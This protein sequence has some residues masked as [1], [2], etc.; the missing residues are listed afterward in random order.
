[1]KMATKVAEKNEEKVAELSHEEKKMLSVM[2]EVAKSM[3]LSEAQ[4]LKAL[5]NPRSAYSIAVAEKLRMNVA[6][7]V[8]TS[9]RRVAS[10]RM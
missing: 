9:E 1:M 2:E 6:T 3:K 4:A 7:L 10:L 5:A 8:Q